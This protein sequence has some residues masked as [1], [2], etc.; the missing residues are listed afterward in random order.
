M[1]GIIAINPKTMKHR[2][3]KQRDG[4]DLQPYSYITIEFEIKKTSKDATAF[5]LQHQ[6]EVTH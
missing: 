4:N 6:Q 1:V 5:T 3:P 2:K